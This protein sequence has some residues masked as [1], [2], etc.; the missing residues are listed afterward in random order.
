MRH[1]SR[2]SMT[3]EL[4]ARHAEAQVAEALS[5][6]RVVLVNGARQSGKS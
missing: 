4:I 2:M 3:R 6:T 5:D 1:D